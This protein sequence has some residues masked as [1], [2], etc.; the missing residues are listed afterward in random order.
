MGGGGGLL[1]THRCHSPKFQL[2]RAPQQ[3]C[4]FCPF[5]VC[6]L[7]CLLLLATAT[8]DTNEGYKTKTGSTSSVTLLKTEYWDRPSGK[9][10]HACKSTRKLVHAIQFECDFTCLVV[11]W[12]GAGGDAAWGSGTTGYCWLPWQPLNKLHCMGGRGSS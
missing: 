10:G 11:I 1:H 5:C 8:L 6:L 12:R 2:T 7:A 3:S 9:V 4:D